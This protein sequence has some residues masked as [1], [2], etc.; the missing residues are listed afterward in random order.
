MVNSI[1][2]FEEKCII[3]FEKLTLFCTGIYNIDMV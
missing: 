3:R 1:K 2:Y